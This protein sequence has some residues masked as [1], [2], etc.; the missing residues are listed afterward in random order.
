MTKNVALYLGRFQ[1]FHL[2]HLDAIDQIIADGVDRI[3]VGIGSSQEELT[4]A[5]PFSYD[6]RKEMINRVLIDSNIK[7]EICSIPD[8]ASNQD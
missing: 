7:F 1:P 8:F 4:R 6:E 3:I 2:G 5:N